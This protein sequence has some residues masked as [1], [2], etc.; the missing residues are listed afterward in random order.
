[1]V[2]RWGRRL[3]THSYDRNLDLRKL[4]WSKNKLLSV[5]SSGIL[6]LDRKSFSATY[7][8]AQGETLPGSGVS[9]VLFSGDRM[10]LSVFPSSQLLIY[11]P[12]D[13]PSPDIVMKERRMDFSDFPI[14]RM[15]VLVE[16]PLQT[17]RFE[18]LSDQDLGISV[19]NQDILPSLL[20]HTGDVYGR[21]WIILVDNR[22]PNN[23]VWEEIRPFL[24]SVIDSSPEESEGGVW[25][26]VGE[27]P[28]AQNFTAYETLLNNSLNRL[29]LYGTAPSENSRSL[30]TAL[31]QAYNALFSLRGPGGII[32][33][34]RHLRN[35][36]GLRRIANRSMNSHYPLVVV[37]PSSG[38]LP[39]S[40]PFEVTDTIKTMNFKN[41]NKNKIWTTYRNALRHH[42]T[43]IYRSNLRFQP[44]SLWQEFQLR[45]YYFDRT[46]RHNSG[47]LFP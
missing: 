6:S 16:D 22:I 45:I 8:S 13:I 17:D 4:W 20:R 32:L 46:G 43:A 1:V 24:E 12:L 15:N 38:S 29:S 3:E 11:R 41:L 36:S 31:N 34:S 7:L 37:N 9:D 21:N 10:V 39:D 35:A 26:T 44:S 18:H 2:N 23:R 14:V 19:D 28:I 47:F 33:V 25:R 30:A 5:S 42:Y 27:N 40:H